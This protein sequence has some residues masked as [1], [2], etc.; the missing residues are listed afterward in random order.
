MSDRLYALRLFARVARAGS[1][2]R[3]AKEMHLSQPSVSRI[4][5]TLEG[6]V[7]A[8]L[9]TRT[10]RAV[11]LTE[12]GAD[13]LSRVE[14][15]LAELEEADH[16]VRGTGELRGILR[17]GVATSFAIREVIPHLPAFMQRH[18]ALKI[19]LQMSDR[20]QN[21]VVEG[22]DVALRFGALPD[23]SA[24]AKRL[25]TSV[26]LLVA[27]PEYLARAGT[28]ASPLDLSAHAIIVGPAASGQ[29]GWTFRRDGRET[30]VA[31]DGRLLVN[32]NEAVTVAAVAGLGIASTGTW[33]CRA[34]LADGRLIQLLA[35][36][37][38]EPVEVHAVLAAGRAAKPSARAFTAYLA[39]VF[40]AM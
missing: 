5:S 6:E 1:F 40:R 15:I 10:T 3:A 19:E 12:A 8:A 16:A 29:I 38:M 18:P 13:Y 22:V 30:S 33:G 25:G 2:S 4:I 35:D 27:S 7:G 17:V 31:V 20:R 34:E 26:R 39:D 28:P 23:S 36:W 9:F 24:L 11:T 37:E 14:R 21:L 32:V